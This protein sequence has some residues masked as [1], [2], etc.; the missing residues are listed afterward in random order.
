MCYFDLDNLVIQDEVLDCGHCLV[1][2]AIYHGRSV[3][4]WLK[5]RN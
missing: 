1:L 5:R 2:E 4:V 3:Q